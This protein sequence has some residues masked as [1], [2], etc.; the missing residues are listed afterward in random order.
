MLGMVMGFCLTACSPYGCVT[1]WL[2][3]LLTNKLDIV[4]AWVLINITERQQVEAWS[5]IL[6]VNLLHPAAWHGIVS[7]AGSAGAVLVAYYGKHLLRLPAPG[8]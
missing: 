2:P 6:G 8:V 4:K 5:H 3:T 7:T 1:A